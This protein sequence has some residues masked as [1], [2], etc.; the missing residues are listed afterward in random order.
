MIN[1]VNEKM[2]F[3]KPLKRRIISWVHKL[4]ILDRN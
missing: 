3:K 2:F 4:S 1:N